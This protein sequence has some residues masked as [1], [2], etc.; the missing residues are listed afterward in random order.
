MTCVSLRMKIVA[1]SPQ[2]FACQGAP[3]DGE[4]AAF[5]SFC[6]SGMLQQMI[7]Y[8]DGLNM[9]WALG[10]VSCW[11]R[12]RLESL[13]RFSKNADAVATTSIS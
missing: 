6:E 12:T 2:G 1:S 11:E 3:A 8:G 9:P 7:Y 10:E 13:S 4:M 5:S